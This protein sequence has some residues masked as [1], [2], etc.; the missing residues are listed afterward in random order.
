MIWRT[1]TA[2]GTGPVKEER[3]CIVVGRQEVGE[4]GLFKAK[5]KLS[6]IKITSLHICLPLLTA[7][8]CSG[9]SNENNMNFLVI[10][11]PFSSFYPMVVN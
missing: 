8:F 4:E 2:A 3:R 1:H 11:I 6:F 10:F 9:E 5:L 7:S